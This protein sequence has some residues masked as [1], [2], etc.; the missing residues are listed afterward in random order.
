MKS[1]ARTLALLLAL[2]ACKDATAPVSPD[3]TVSA[4][5]DETGRLATVRLMDACDPTTFAVVPGGCQRDGGI[6]LDQFT[7]QLTALQTVPAWHMSPLDLYIKEGDSF[8]AYNAGG[9]NHTFTEVEEFGGGVV[10]SLNLLAGLTTVAPECVGAVPS[11]IIAPGETS[12]VDTPD[13][14][15][16]EHYQCCI[17]PWMR[18]TV[19]VRE[20]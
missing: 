4:V 18:T 13:E 9:E 19:H 1:A 5:K 2:A 20:R 12:D 16:D 11:G 14:A 6:T 15:E 7:A 3:L 17:H 10:P 8:Q